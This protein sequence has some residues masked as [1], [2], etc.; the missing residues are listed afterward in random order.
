MSLRLRSILAAAIATMLA[1]VVLG[2]AVDVLVA[3]HLHHGLDKTLR[4][5]AIGVAQL[6]ASAPALLTT[7]GALDAPVGGTQALVE[8]VDRKRPDRRA[9]A[10]ARRT[11][12]AADDRAGRDRQRSTA[13]YRTIAFG[14]ASACAS[15]RRRSRTCGRGRRRGPRRGVD[16]RPHRHD[17]HAARG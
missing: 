4:T 8:V 16:G 7:P 9:L 6:A 1:V 5:R 10:L 17:P 15:T 11:R 13:R 14:G 3:R 2:S 12:A